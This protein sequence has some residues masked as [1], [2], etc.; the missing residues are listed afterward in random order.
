MI[1]LQEGSVRLGAV[2]VRDLGSGHLRERVAM[3]P[4]E[5]E[6][7]PGS[8][9]DNV[10]L[11]DD[12]VPAAAVAGAFQRLGAGTWLR[13][14]GDGVDTVI[15]PG[16][17]ELSSGERQLVAISRILLREPSLVILDEPAARIDPAT[18]VLVR[19]ALA[20]LLRGRTGLVIAHRRSTLDLVDSVALLERG[21]IVERIPRS[22][23]E[24][25]RESS[26]A[27]FLARGEMA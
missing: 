19:G 25:T 15:G 7:V 23:L 26:V 11:F 9:R 20:Q 24:A 10:A 13:G 6:I 12:S 2:A 27:A 16:G 22:R 3:L 8:L 14:L 4:Q 21:A 18:E 5:T 1:E 17:R